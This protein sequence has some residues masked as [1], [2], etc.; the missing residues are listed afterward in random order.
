M[1]DT[2]GEIVAPA[3]RPHLVKFYFSTGRPERRVY[4]LVPDLH[5]VH[6]SNNLVHSSNNTGVVLNCCYLGLENLS[7][8]PLVAKPDLLALA[9]AGPR[10]Q[11]SD[12]CATTAG[13]DAPPGS[14]WAWCKRRGAPACPSPSLPS[15]FSCPS[16]SPSCLNPCFL[17]SKRLRNMCN[18]I[19]TVL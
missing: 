12:V 2:L 10:G 1:C 4:I 3:G 8:L 18:Y 11:H 5:G 6:S 14:P 17:T 15:F 19:Q 7:T 9:A 16:S 13:Q